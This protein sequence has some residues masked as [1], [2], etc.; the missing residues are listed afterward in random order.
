MKSTLSTIFDFKKENGYHYRIVST[1]ESKECTL[2]GYKCVPGYDKISLGKGEYG[3]L[4]RIEQEIYEKR[5]KDRDTHSNK[6]FRKMQKKIKDKL[7]EERD[8]YL[9]IINGTINREEV[10]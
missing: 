8:F 2:I 3:T 5:Q 7:G 1:R 10:L 9:S 4:M 6:E